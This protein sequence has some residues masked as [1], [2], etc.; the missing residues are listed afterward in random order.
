MIATPQ[1]LLTGSPPQRV[2]YTRQHAFGELWVWPVPTL[3]QD[4]VIYWRQPLAQ[5]P[6]LV[7]AVDLAPGYA[8]A[9]R[10]NL[11]VE[12]A[13]EFGRRPDPIIDRAAHESLADV[14]RQNFPLVEIG[15]D[16]ALTGGGR[17]YNILTG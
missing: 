11:A 15:I 8:R 14:K 5:F 1:K 16:P 12:L 4:L 9:L 17:G 6:D 13:P 10:Y 2:N 3:A 7:T